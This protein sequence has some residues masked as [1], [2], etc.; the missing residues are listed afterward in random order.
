[1][2][3]FFP[4]SFHFLRPVKLLQLLGFFVVLTFVF[5]Q[6]VGYLQLFE[7][8]IWLA[9]LPVDHNI[10]SVMFFIAFIYGFIFGAPFHFS[11][12]EDKL[13]YSVRLCQFFCGV[14]FLG[15]A[16]VLLHVYSLWLFVITS[17]VVAGFAKIVVW[18]DK[19]LKNAGELFIVAVL[20]VLVVLF[21]FFN[22]T[23][24]AW[25]VASVIF[26]FLFMVLG[27]VCVYL[28]CADILKK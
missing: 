28:P 15:I 12:L 26:G 3:Q 6:V 5:A 19:L 1:M 2:V 14:S 24:I 7:L 20:A 8:P 21:L 13:D 10:Y 11:D 25:L 4:I 18:V 27:S 17:V 9:V 22:D 16:Y 23:S